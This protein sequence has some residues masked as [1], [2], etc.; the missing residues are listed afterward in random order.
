[1]GCEHLRGRKSWAK[2]GGVCGHCPTIRRERE[3]LRVISIV[4]GDKVIWDWFFCIDCNRISSREQEKNEKLELTALH[5]PLAEVNAAY[6]TQDKCSKSQ[7]DGGGGHHPKKRPGHV[8]P[9]ERG[10]IE[11]CCPARKVSSTESKKY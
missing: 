5:K 9:S 3:L 4:H 1:M 6:D 10:G 8:C 2:Y 11:H 7:E